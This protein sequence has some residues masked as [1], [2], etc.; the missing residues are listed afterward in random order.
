MEESNQSP[1]KILSFSDVKQLIEQ[2]VNAIIDTELLTKMTEIARILSQLTFQPNDDLDDFPRPIQTEENLKR[3]KVEK[4]GDA[5][6]NV[7][8]CNRQLATLIPVFKKQARYLIHIANSIK[9]WIRL[10]VPRIED[11][12]VVGVIIQEDVIREMEN[13]ENQTR[14]SLSHV[15][16]YHE[17]RAEYVKKMLKYPE[18]EDYYQTVVAYDY[19]MTNVVHSDMLRICNNYV[20]LHDILTKNME[21]IK[22]PLGTNPVNMHL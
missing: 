17:F 20:I 4:N 15:Y 21:K 11:K 3:R 10:N 14:V 7:V 19:Q 5:N 18:I 1:K 2:R 12:D 8:S 9:V 13:V 6:C 16:G 22:H